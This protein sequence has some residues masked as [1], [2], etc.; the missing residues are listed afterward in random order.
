MSI[1]LAA[2]L[3]C[4]IC[5]GARLGI[6][7]FRGPSILTWINLKKSSFYAQ[8]YRIGFFVDL[9]VLGN[10]E[11]INKLYL[12]ISFIFTYTVIEYAH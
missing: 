4:T 11:C 7:F 8:I 2:L 3:S 9:I 5:Q 1:G 6:C 12:Y 10:N